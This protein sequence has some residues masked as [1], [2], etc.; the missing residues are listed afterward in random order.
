M[1]KEDLTIEPIRPADIPA[2]CELQTRAFNGIF[3]KLL[4]FV[5]PIR[6]EGV[7]IANRF[8][9]PQTEGRVLRDKDG[10]IRAA[11]MIQ[12][13][14]SR[15]VGGPAAV[16]PDFRRR[17]AFRDL[18]APLLV[19][20]RE[21]YGVIATEL[22]TFPH[23]VLHFGTN[24]GLG[25]EPLFPAPAMKKDLSKRAAEPKRS[26]RVERYSRFSEA[27]Q[28]QA[29]R[30]VGAIC[31]KI[32]E[33]FDVSVE[34]THVFD[35][36]LGDSLFAYN[37]EKIVGFAICH[38][39]PGSEAFVDDELSIK[40]AFVDTDAPNAAGVFEALLESAEDIAASE[41][42]ARVHTMVSGGRRI[43]LDILRR[44]EYAAAEVHAG[45]VFFLPPEDE[46]LMSSAER[47]AEWKRILLAVDAHPFVLAELR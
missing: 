46:A 36:K 8:F 39:G 42:L 15:G 35:R 29:L 12:V 32:F 23:S 17:R 31:G 37:G 38:Y 45:Y 6:P 33:R 47:R 43:A 3:K 11:N 21:H 26:T 22:V 41:K 13:S 9:R 18:S 4:G 28:Q 44:R 20:V 5:P 19:H 10:F 40:T 2:I 16:D 14:G 1:T 27:N 34:V 7:R 30:A 25:A 24:Q